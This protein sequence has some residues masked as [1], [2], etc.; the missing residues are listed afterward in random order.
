MLHGG[1]G[2][3][4]NVDTSPAKVCMYFPSDG[5][6]GLPLGCESIL[7][8]VDVPIAMAKFGQKQVKKVHNVDA[9]HIPHAVDMNNYFP[10]SEEKRK[11]L[12]K[13]WKI[14]DKFVIGVMA[15]NQGRKF[16]DR[17]LKFM[18]LYAKQ[19]PD[20]VMLMH[21][22]PNDP[23]QPFPL[24]SLIERYGLE[25]R[26]MF[27]GT[28]YY[29]GF[30]YKDMHEI[31][32]L[33]DCYLHTSSGEGFGIGLI[34]SMACE[35]PVVGTN[36]TTTKEIVLD[37]DAGL[38][39]DLVGMSEDEHVDIHGAEILE[40]TIT[41]SWSVERG[42]CSIKDALKKV[43]YLYKNPEERKR[44]GKNGRAA[45]ARTYNWDVIKKQWLELINKLGGQY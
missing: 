32:N 23:A 34:E 1:N 19:N 9:E 4:L 3:F 17:S 18:S 43:D 12:R 27:T 15:R 28:T 2:W 6:G 22:D 21:C 30:N 7:K 8:K 39:I 44:L 24:M 38:G 14:D 20:A 37:N 35:V 16:L 29:K 33:M 11:E 31:Y 42:I 5:G 26:V 25:N 10:L 36:Y 40:G 41:G 45:V 13:K